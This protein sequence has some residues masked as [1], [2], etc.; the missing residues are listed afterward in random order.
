M[1]VESDMDAVS[2]VD[3]ICMNS[4]EV[5]VPSDFST[6]KTEVEVSLVLRSFFIV[7]MV[8]N[9]CVYACVCTVH[10]CVLHMRNNV[11]LNNYLAA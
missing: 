4:D 2:E 5:Y 10:S 9:L 7:V 8:V 3:P 6:I 1:K 11:I